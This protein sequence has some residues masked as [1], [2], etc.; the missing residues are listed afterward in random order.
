MDTW[1]Y[2]LRAKAAEA[3]HY[4]PSSAKVM[5]VSNFSSIVPYAFMV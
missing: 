3:D 2:F 5:I 1:A 4:P